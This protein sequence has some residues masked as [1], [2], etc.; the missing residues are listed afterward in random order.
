ML[1]L[2]GFPISNYYNRV[3]LVLLEKGLPFEEV[4]ANP[5]KGDELVKR[6]SPAGRVPFLEVSE[7]QFLSESL[8]IMEYL[9]ETYPAT[10]LLPEDP[11]ARARVRELI[12]TIDWNLEWVARRLYE[13]C[14]AGGKVSDETKQQVQKS[15]HRGAHALERL[16]KFEPYIAG[17]QY[18]LADC[19][20]AVHLP[21]ISISSKLTY[22]SD[23]LE[24]L[25]PKIKP[26]LKML[27]ERSAVAKVNADRKAAVQAGKA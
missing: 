1:K 16:V 10:P 13:E 18:T 14:F 11:L 21:L 4:M 20:A 9:E 27:G 7:G 2:Y 19:T 25:A 15:L 22:G 23:A 17:G 12:L 3:K 8:A 26:Y 6:H 24:T 5:E